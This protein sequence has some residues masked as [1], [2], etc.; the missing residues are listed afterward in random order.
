MF[1]SASCKFNLYKA[2][3]ATPQH[4]ITPHAC[5]LP[6]FSVQLLFLHIPFLVS[7]SNLN[8]P[9]SF[10]HPSTFST[11]I[12]PSVFNITC[13]HPSAFLSI[14]QQSL[15]PFSILYYSSIYTT[16]IPFTILY[17]FWDLPTVPFRTFLLLL[18]IPLYT[19]TLLLTLSTSYYPP[20]SPITIPYSIS[21]KPSTFCFALQCFRLPLSIFYC[22]PFQLFLSYKCKNCALLR[23]VVYTKE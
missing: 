9:S 8:N 12:F 16:M 19:S 21:Y 6:T 2:L 15:L 11:V 5:M 23:C 14:P 1:C 13:Q 7:L 20:H 22:S 3:F 18:S 10:Q 4:S 17:S